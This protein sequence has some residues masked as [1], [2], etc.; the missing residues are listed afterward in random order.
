MHFTEET[1]FLPSGPLIVYEL[2]TTHKEISKENTKIPAH[3]HVSDGANPGK[4]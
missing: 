3:Y 1:G 4:K 2:I